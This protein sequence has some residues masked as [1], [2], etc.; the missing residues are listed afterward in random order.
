M[1]EHITK[2]KKKIFNK[3]RDLVI[4]KSTTVIERL[5]ANQTIIRCRK[6]NKDRRRFLNCR[7]YNEI[8]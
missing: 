4:Y 5:L 2:K 8:S 7:T 1:Y 6:K 3:E